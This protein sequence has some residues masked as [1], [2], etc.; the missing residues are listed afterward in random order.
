MDENIPPYIKKYINVCNPKI[1]MRQVFIGQRK[2]ATGYLDFINND[3]FLTDNIVYGYDCYN[4]FFISVMYNE[5]K[6]VN[7]NN[8]ATTNSY[9]YYSNN[10]DINN[11]D[12][13]NDINEDIDSKKIMTVFQRYTDHSTFFVSCGSTFSYQSD[14]KSWVA[15]S[16]KMDPQ[17]QDFFQLINASYVKQYKLYNF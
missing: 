4:R 11:D 8:A 9:S 16:D 2:G 3:D 17:F 13:N 14:V 12:I 15:N 6:N 7:V 10:D 5:N 1:S